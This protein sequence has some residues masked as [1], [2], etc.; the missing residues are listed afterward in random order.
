MGG[1]EWKQHRNVKGKKKRWSEERKQI[2]DSNRNFI[3]EKF[4]NFIIVRK[5]NDKNKKNSKT[6]HIYKILI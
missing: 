3:L 1:G 6:L 4:D 5:F 2:R